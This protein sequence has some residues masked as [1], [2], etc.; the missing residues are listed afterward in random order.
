MDLHTLSQVLKSA[1]RPPIIH[2][3]RVTGYETK[4]WGA[5]PAHLRGRPLSSVN[6][7]V[8]ELLSQIPIDRLAAYE[9]NKHRLEACLIEPLND[10]G[11]VKHIIEG[12]FFMWNGRPDELQDGTFDLKQWKKEKQLQDL[13]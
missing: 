6:G 1:K 7:F 8:S 12:I 3:A 5:Y 4:L 10:D 9:T 13:G 2:R 11:S